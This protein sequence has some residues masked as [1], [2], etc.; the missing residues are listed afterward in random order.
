MYNT[1]L[2]AFLLYRFVY[3]N[4]IATIRGRVSICINTH[5]HLHGSRL[6]AYL[7]DPLTHIHWGRGKSQPNPKRWMFKSEIENR[8]TFF[9]IISFKILLTWRPDCGEVRNFSVDFVRSGGL[10]CVLYSVWFSNNQRKI[11]FFF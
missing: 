3:L 2:S 9:F 10:W 5:T 11:S 7:C 6:Y 4:K 8:N 1:R